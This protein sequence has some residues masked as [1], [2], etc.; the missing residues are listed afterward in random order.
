MKLCLKLVSPKTIIQ[1]DKEYDFTNIR[2]T[3]LKFTCL[4][5]NINILFILF[6]NMPSFN[7]QYYDGINNINY[8]FMTLTPSNGQTIFYANNNDNQYD[9]TGGE[10]IMSLDLEIKHDNNE[11]SY[12]V[13]PENPLIL[14]LEY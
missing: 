11:Y 9:L 2:L 13:T 6:K 1:F 10:K 7:N 3:K 12:S 8:T 4:H 5:D 14:E